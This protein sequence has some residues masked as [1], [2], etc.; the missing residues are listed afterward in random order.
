MN[1]YSM[2]SINPRVKLWLIISSI[3]KNEKI[4]I[5]STNF[6]ELIIYLHRV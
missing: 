2:L 4:F 1:N 5:N 6:I 3:K